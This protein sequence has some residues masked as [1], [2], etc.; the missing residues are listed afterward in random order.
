LGVL[1]SHVRYVPW[2]RPWLFAIQNRFRLLLHRLVEIQRRRCANRG[3]AREAA[4][5]LILPASVWYRIKN[6]ISRDRAT[7]IWTR[8]MSMCLDEPLRHAL[9]QLQLYVSNTSR[10]WEAKIGTIIPRDPQVEAFGDASEL[11]GGGFCPELHFWFDVL[12]SQQVRDALLLPS[13]SPHFIHINMLEFVV[14]ILTV[15]AILVAFQTLTPDERVS[16]FPNGIPAIPVVRDRCDNTSAVSWANKATT[17]SYQGQKLL[18]IY[19]ELLRCHDLCLR[20]D[21]IAG[22]INVVADTISRPTNCSLS[23]AAR[24]EQLFQSHPIMRSWR[25][26]LPSPELLQ[27]LTC[28]L[29]S[30]LPAV[31]PSLPPGLGQL[32]RV[33]STSSCSPSI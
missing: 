11:G 21:H 33:A 22:E 28:A 29:F 18:G 6:I 8:R 10:P 1:E 9:T 32:V 17:S 26:F 4:L 31:P 25:I 24:S 14:V 15:A 30:P 20:S 3:S 7:F 5:Q 27:L 13:D 23:H 12:W 19:S 16:W 2:A